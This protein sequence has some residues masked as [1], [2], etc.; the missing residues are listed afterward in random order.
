MGVVGAYV[1]LHSAL[2]YVTPADMLAGK[3]KEIFAER[4]AKLEQARQRR[5]EARQQQRQARATAGNASKAA[6]NENTRSEDRA[7]LGNNPSA[8]SMP[9]AD[10][11]VQSSAADAVLSSTTS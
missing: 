4:D 10:D 9:L 5:A 6:Y 3:Q 7:L 1:R 8:A 11:G 2:G